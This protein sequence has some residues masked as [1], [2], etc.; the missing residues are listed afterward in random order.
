M[1][2]NQQNKID[3][4]ILE[5]ERRRHKQTLDAVLSGNKIQAWI[6]V[7]LC[8]TLGVAAFSAWLTYTKG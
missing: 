6:L 5:E 4:E 8:A 2:K 3:G 1:E 7:V